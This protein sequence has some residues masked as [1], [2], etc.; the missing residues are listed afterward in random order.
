MLVLSCSIWSIDV[1]WLDRG[2]RSDDR[3]ARPTRIPGG[4]WLDGAQVVGRSGSEDAA[5][6][7]VLWLM[8]GLTVE[9][10]HPP[11][12]RLQHSNY[13]LLNAKFFRWQRILVYSEHW[14]GL[15]TK[16]ALYPDCFGLWRGNPPTSFRG[17]CCGGPRLPPG[18][19][20]E[21]RIGEGKVVLLHFRY[22]LAPQAS[23]MRNNE[24]HY[25]VKL[26]S[27]NQGRQS[28]R[29]FRKL[30]WITVKRILQ[31]HET[32]SLLIGFLRIA[33]SIA[34]YFDR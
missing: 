10:W 13:L 33:V 30:G 22:V 12:K 18:A 14:L 11:T 16:P 19:A 29:R 8:N 26:T 23:R 5:C 17:I 6:L 24:R 21:I 15:K 34:R 9:W 1:S 28:E 31:S 20:A 3:T 25:M 27:T 4:L 2:R 32:P 7:G